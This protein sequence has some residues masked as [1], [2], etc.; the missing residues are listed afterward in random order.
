[1]PRLRAIW[2]AQ[3]DARTVQ[4]VL[5]ADVPPE[6]QAFYQNPTATSAWSQAT[7]ADLLALQSGTMVEEVGSLSFNR[8]VSM[9]DLQD[10]SERRWAEF[11]DHI[12]KRNPFSHS[13]TTWDGR[14]WVM[15]GP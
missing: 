3:P 13:G 4:Y 1:M 8:K 15:K 11:Q 10:E 6:V 14:T 12:T 7:A 9:T 5:W 2:L